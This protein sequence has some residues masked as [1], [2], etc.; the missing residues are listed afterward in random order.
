MSASNRLRTITI[1][2]VLAAV[3]GVLALKRGAADGRTGAEAAASGEP[4]ASAPEGLPSPDSPAAGAPAA[5]AA[6]EPLAAG[7]DGRTDVPGGAAD[8][9]PAVAAAASPLPKLLDLG[10]GKCIPCRRM[11]P[12]LAELEETFAGALEVEFIDV[13][14]NP[15]AAKPWGVRLI[16]TQ[17]FLDPQGRELFRHEG[18][19]ARED[20]LAQWKRLGYALEPV[21]T[22][23]GDGT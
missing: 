21:T 22:A 14:E 15:D 23:N 1:V 11:M 10:A 16:P 17:I 20:I 8:G 13:W 5:G 12:I 9:G 19:F 4:P 18:F 3:V 6:S 7:P 2:V